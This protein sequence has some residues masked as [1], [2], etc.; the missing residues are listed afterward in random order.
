MLQLS[1]SRGA[2][3]PLLEKTISQALA[4]TAARF[5]GREAL[6]VCHQN[7][8]L[9]WS[10]LDGEATRVARGLAGLGLAPGDRAGIWASNCVE[11]IL[12]QHAAARSGVVLVNVNP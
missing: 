11:W 4:D 3:V 7:V 1:Y 10:E 2:A 5:P 6:V 8:R 9:T 12:M